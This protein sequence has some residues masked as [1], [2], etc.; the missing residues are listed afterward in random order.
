MSRLTKRS[1]HTSE[2]AERP[3][4][5]LKFLKKRGSFDIT[6]KINLN[7]SSSMSNYNDQFAHFTTVS[8]INSSTKASE[9]PL[10]RKSFKSSSASRCP[11]TLE[12]NKLE[13]TRFWEIIERIESLELRITKNLDKSPNS[14]LLLWKNC[15]SEVVSMIKAENQ[16]LALVINRL[17]KGCLSALDEVCVEVTSE[18]GKQEKMIREQGDLIK[19]KDLEIGRLSREIKAFNEVKLAQDWKINKQI[20]E[21][22]AEYEDEGEVVKARSQCDTLLKDKGNGLVPLLKEIYENLK[23]GRDGQELIENEF[24]QPHP[25]DIS[26]ALKFNFNL[27][28]QAS[29]KKAMKLLRKDI[30]TKVVASQTMIACVSSDEY[31]DLMKK[32]EKSTISQQSLAA[33]LEKYRDDV[34]N[35]S[36][37][38]EKA[39][40]DKNQAFNQII[41]MRKEIETY[42]KEMA[43]IKKDNEKLNNDKEKIVKELD[44]KSDQLN[45]TQD[46]LISI[47]NKMKK[48]I[49]RTTQPQSFINDF[50]KSAPPSKQNSEKELVVLTNEVT[51]YTVRG[52]V[53]MNSRK[54]SRSNIY[55]GKSFVYEG[56]LGKPKNL[57]SNNSSR[58]SLL[59]DYIEAMNKPTKPRKSS[60]VLNVASKDRRRS[61]VVSYENSPIHNRG[62]DT[63]NRMD[64]LEKPDNSNLKK[65]SLKINILNPQ[66]V[67]DSDP[68]DHSPTKVE[69]NQ[70]DKNKHGSK[71]VRKKGKKP[72]QT[73]KKDDSPFKDSHHEE[74][75][76]SQTAQRVIEINGKSITLVDESTNTS[77]KISTFCS[78]SIQ[79]GGEESDPANSKDRFGSLNLFH[80]NPNNY[81]GFKG[82]VFYNSSGQVFS[83][84]PTMPDYPMALGKNN[85]L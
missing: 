45:K 22:F 60:Q 52:R 49:S 7:L 84:Q 62:T 56:S 46:K 44:L 26:N 70:K 34:I 2:S 69:K 8:K 67:E 15:C 4:I 53:G 13:S 16:E 14:K 81:F 37:I 63:E 83:A 5:P 48:L 17:V 11:N 51:K 12:S 41:K 54:N 24:D 55:E 71:N 39:E 3:S 10:N 18:K 76:I 73:G 28:L 50:E 1:I 19:G 78:I 27:I 38:A 82:D 33:Q 74:V 32:L 47:E 29:T 66:N 79:C 64:G 80:F 85:N 6:E 40:Q 57:N 35:K 25:D 42:L 43:G 58:A 61:S 20:K 72:S 77:E 65:M 31:Q 23:K 21:M 75:D 59:D 68:E 9:S 30:K 36:I